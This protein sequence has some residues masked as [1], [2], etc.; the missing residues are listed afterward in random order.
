MNHFYTLIMEC[1]GG[2]KKKKSFEM[3][4]TNKK[5]KIQKK[6]SLRHPEECLIFPKFNTKKKEYLES[7]IKDFENIYLNLKENNFN[8]KNKVFHP[9]YN[10]LLKDV[11][12]NYDFKICNKEIY[13]KNMQNKFGTCS[14]FLYHLYNADNSIKYI[15]PYIFNEEYIEEL[16]LDAKDILFKYYSMNHENTYIDIENKKKIHEPLKIFEEN[17]EKI[18]GPP[19]LIP[20]INRKKALSLC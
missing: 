16:K 5:P 15:Y 20:L 9:N 6:L 11:H 2:I 19:L 8:M 3:N 4:D 18:P 14:T 1:I 17:E 10:I 7:T 13:L 12:P